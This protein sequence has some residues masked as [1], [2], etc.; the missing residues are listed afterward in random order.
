LALA[1]DPPF[2]FKKTSRAAAQ[3]YMRSMTTFEGY[4][5]AEIAAIEARLGVQFTDVFRSYLRHMG[6]SRGYLF[7]GSDV[8]QPSQFEDF[9]QF[10]QKLM[11]ETSRS[12]DLPRDA[13]VF[14]SHQGYQFLFI[15]PRGG[16][17]CAVMNYV[18]T[19]EAAKQIAESFA[20]FLDAELR[21]MEHNHR[22]SHETGGHYITVHKRGGTSFKYPARASG[23][24]ATDRPFKL[25]DWW[26][27][28]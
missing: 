9:R 20:A 21:L 18:E 22:K 23:D 28:L 12:L 6:K 3:Q 16:F 26:R 2:R 5:Q 25:G 10:G 1:V 27:L 4:S 13:I 19:E 15:Q 24:R 14:L 8:A 17:D 11:H 7:G